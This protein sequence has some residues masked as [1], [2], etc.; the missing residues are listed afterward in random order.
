MKCLGSLDHLRNAL[1]SDITS[2]LSV[3][4]DG[5][6]QYSRKLFTKKILRFFINC[7]RSLYNFFLIWLTDIIFYSMQYVLVQ[8]DQ[9]SEWLEES[10]QR[11]TKRTEIIK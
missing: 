8:H 10:S 3:R 5:L 2:R 11:L 1:D 6:Q 7:L 9:L 4:C